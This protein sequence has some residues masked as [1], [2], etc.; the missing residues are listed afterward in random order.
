MCLV[1]FTTTRGRCDLRE[2][3]KER[4]ALFPLKLWAP[5][6]RAGQRRGS[7]TARGAAFA[8]RISKGLVKGVFRDAA[9]AN[10]GLHEAFVLRCAA[11][12]E[13][14]LVVVQ[15]VVKTRVAG[16]GSKLSRE[17]LPLSSLGLFFSEF[18]THEPLCVLVTHERN[19][20]ARLFPAACERALFPKVRSRVPESRAQLARVFPSVLKKAG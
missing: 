1:S 7:H 13:A 17:Q 9:R 15:P 11:R 18:C 12:E 6:C 20:F 19:H 3:E 16:K 4:E 10:P 14:A 2:R 5:L 8:S